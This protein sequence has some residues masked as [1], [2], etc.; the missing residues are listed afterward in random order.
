MSRPKEVPGSD[1]VAE[2]AMN[3]GPG[4]EAPAL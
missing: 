2:A 3:T 1:A 4:W